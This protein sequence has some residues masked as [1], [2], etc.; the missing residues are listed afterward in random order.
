VNSFIFSWLSQCLS[1]ALTA[2]C[3]TLSARAA[4]V[5]EPAR[6]IA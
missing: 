3:V 6:M 2:G 5:T 1:T 4:P